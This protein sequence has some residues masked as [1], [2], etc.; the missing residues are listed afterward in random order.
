MNEL[1]LFAVCLLMT[2]AALPLH[3][4]AHP[5][6]SGRHPQHQAQAPSPKP[7]PAA[8]A[9]AS[10]EPAAE[11][12]ADM[13]TATFGDWQLRCR[14]TPAAAGKPAQRGCEVVQTVILKGQTAPFAQLGFGKLTPA[15][16]LFFTAVVP[17]NITFEGNVKL[18]I[19]E[20]DK[21]PVEIPW[22]R[23]L[24]G[25]CFASV[26]VKEDVLKRWRAQNKGGRLMF[27]NG[28]GQNLIVPMSFRG[29]DR[30]LDALAK[31]S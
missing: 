18:A 20:N 30:A 25:G 29:L 13:T 14:L 10:A 4:Q 9:P 16:P 6:R 26:A 17:T 8:P 31:E 1:R 2:Q 19:D 11:A 28:A 7:A 27:R 24:P 23:C 22:S 5:P 12:N 3:A 15:D 21:Q